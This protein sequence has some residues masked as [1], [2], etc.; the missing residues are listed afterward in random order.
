[1]YPA[2]ER[3]RIHQQNNLPEL[4]KLDVSKLG[5]PWHKLPKLMNDSFDILDARLSIYFLKKLRVNA[6][7]ES[8]TFVID[9]HYKNAQI[10]STPYGN[11]GFV[12]DRILLLNV[13]HDYYGLS[14]DT[15]HIAPDESLPVTKTEERLKSKLG[16]ELTSLI[17]CKETFGEELDIRVDYSSVINQWVWGITFTLAGYSHGSFTVLLDNHHVDQMLATLRAPDGSARAVEQS[18]SLSPAQIERLFDSLPLKLTGRLASLNLTVAQIADIKPGDI[19]PIAINEPVP[20]FIG[21]EQ[22]FEAAI[23]E[24]R[25]KLFLCDI[26]DK[27]T[28][29]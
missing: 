13:L 15:N 16:Q 9:K 21:K 24:D 5:R 25:S 14:K 17:I 1:M 6:A 12:I 29:K 20:V 27:T 3:I 7:L 11:I 18:M 4:V 23:A 10:F 19:I 28:E 8:M 22:I 2:S 26:H